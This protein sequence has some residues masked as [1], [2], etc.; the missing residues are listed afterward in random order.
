[1]NTPGFHG[2]FNRYTREEME[3]FQEAEL[4]RNAEE[5]A[6]YFAWKRGDFP[7][8][9]P[10]P[11]YT[12]PN[13]DAYAPP[14]AKPEGNTHAPLHERSPSEYDAQPDPIPRTQH[15]F[16]DLLYH[17]RAERER[18]ENPNAPPSQRRTTLWTEDQKRVMFEEDP[19]VAREREEKRERV[20]IDSVDV[21]DY[22]V[23]GTERRM[24][25]MADELEGFSKEV[26][27]EVERVEE[28]RAEESQRRGKE[29]RDLYGMR[30]ED[31]R[32]GAR[33]KER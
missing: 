22:S 23:E 4:R 31:V 25:A 8:G 21:T 30:F 5:Q 18:R 32:P 24:R 11:K 10:P 29:I 7:V 9:T 19:D 1:V 2:P 16:D 14:I 20:D 27:K 28:L 13:P 12:P 17:E 3:S 15:H 6:A 26:R 33:N